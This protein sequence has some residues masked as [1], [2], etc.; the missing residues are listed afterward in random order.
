MTTQLVQKYNWYGERK[1]HLRCWIRYFSIS[2]QVKILVGK[3]GKNIPELPLPALS[4]ELY[5]KNLR[6]GGALT[7]RQEESLK[8]C[9]HC[10]IGIH[11]RIVSPIPGRYLTEQVIS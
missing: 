11:I 2:Q 7:A 5:M 4:N 10:D 1:C 3:K 8:K 9:M 6:G